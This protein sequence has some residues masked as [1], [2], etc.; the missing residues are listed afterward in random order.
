MTAY[1]AAQLTT[2]FQIQALDPSLG[3][4]EMLLN[5]KWPEEVLNQKTPCWRLSVL[6]KDVAN[7]LL[8]GQIHT[9]FGNSLWSATKD[10]ALSFL[11]EPSVRNSISWLKDPVLVLSKRSSGH[12]YSL[13]AYELRQ[14][15]DFKGVMRVFE[16]EGYAFVYDPGARAEERDIVAINAK[17]Y[18]TDVVDVSYPASA[19]WLGCVPKKLS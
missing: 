13:N 16:S 6:T 12:P 7:S 14:R 18:P 2:L 19:G 1:S 17:L 15:E 11:Q 3:S 5:F 4:S 10:G 8:A 9:L